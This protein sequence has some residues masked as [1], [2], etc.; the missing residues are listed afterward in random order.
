MKYKWLIAGG[1]MLALLA[2]C[3]GIVFASWVGIAGLR[4][5]GVSWRLF[6]VDTISAEAD[7]EQR[8]AV[9]G[10]ATFTLENSAGKVTVT[11]GT[12]KEIVIAAHKTAWGATQAG[13]EAALTALK[14]IVTQNGDAVTVRVEQPQKVVVAGSSRSDT[15][16]FTISVPTETAVS[17]HAS[18]GDVTL[19]G[20][21]GAA[22]LKTDFGDVSVHDVKGGV[23]AKTSSGG[24]DVQQSGAEGARLD[25]Q[26]DFG[27]ITL[28]DAT[29]G[30]TQIHTSSGEVTLTQV[31]ASGALTV[32]SDFGGLTLKQVDAASYDLRTS[33]GK[34]MV[35]DAR[36]GL[37]AHTDFGDIEVS[38]AEAVTLDLSTS[39][40][41]IRFAGSLTGGP[42]TLKT[43]F[44][45][46]RLALPEKTALTLDL[47]TDFGQ[48]KSAFPI[49]TSGELK[50]DHWQGAINGGGAS[51]TAHTSSGDISLEIL[52]P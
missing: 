14:I 19:S 26:S 33:S 18:F 7:E 20:T 21:T 23:T 37:K 4:R 31:A 36:G 45:N 32:K 11:G 38:G 49:T 12:G 16:D 6:S 3:A 51:L 10:P 43:D 41:S 29:A 47:K 39:S 44:G 52:N 50:D 9:S 13:A 15:V 24:I 48:I 40:G 27:E 22:D 34:I 46:V 25:L 30:E 5:T 1:L 2:L 28:E 17:A 8:A 42:H 35:Q